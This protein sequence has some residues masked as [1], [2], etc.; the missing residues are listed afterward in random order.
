MMATD[1]NFGTTAADLLRHIPHGAWPLGGGHAERQMVDLMA[2]KVT[3]RTGD[4]A[5]SRFRAK[6]RPHARY[7]S[8]LR[9]FW[10][11]APTLWPAI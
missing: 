2:I 11:N 5:R 9:A 7:E 1:G 6:E 10:S 3:M 8:P 4:P